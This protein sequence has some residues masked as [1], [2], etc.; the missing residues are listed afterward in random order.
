MSL[1]SFLTRLRFLLTR[2]PAVSMTSSTSTST[3][4]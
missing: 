1:A 4:P 2:R 3:V